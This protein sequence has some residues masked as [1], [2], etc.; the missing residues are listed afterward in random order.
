[1]N[2]MALYFSFAVAALLFGAIAPNHPS[3]PLGSYQKDCSS[4]SI[5]DDRLHAT[6]QNQTGQAVRTS[7]AH[8]SKCVLNNADIV[9]FEGHLICSDITHLL[10]GSNS[11]SPANTP[12]K[13]VSV[14]DNGE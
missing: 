5:E 8:A 7:L 3:L 4:I 2:F 10:S 13:L 1:M 14:H 6:C 9:V 12:L 11:N